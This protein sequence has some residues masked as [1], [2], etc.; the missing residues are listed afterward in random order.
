MD[1]KES[2]IKSIVEESN[3]TIKSTVFRGRSSSILKQPNVQNE[4]KNN[5]STRRVSFSSNYIKTFTTDTEKNTIWDTTVEE[6]LSAAESSNSREGH[7]LNTTLFNGK[8]NESE[9]GESESSEDDF[10]RDRASTKNSADISLMEFT[11]VNS[12][13][14]SNV[15]KPDDPTNTSGSSPD[16][17]VTMD[18]TCV[19]P[20][21]HSKSGNQSTCSQSTNTEDSSVS[22]E[23]TCV[24][25]TFPLKSGNQSTTTEDSSISMEFTCVNPTFH[26]KPGNQSTY[27]QSTITKDSSVSMELTCV[28][29]IFHSNTKQKPADTSESVNTSHTAKIQD[30]GNT[31]VSM[32]FTCVNPIFHLNNEKKQADTSESFNAPHT[33]KIHNPENTSVP[34]EL[35]CVNPTFHS[36]TKKDQV[37]TF[38]ASRTAEIQNPGDTSLSMEFT[39]VNPTLPLNTKQATGLFNTPHTDKIQNPENTSVSMEFTCVNP[40]LHLNTKKTAESFNA[41]HTAKIQNPGNTSVSMEFTCVNPTLHSNTKKTSES[42]NASHTAKIPNPGN[43]TVPMELTCV[44]PAFNLSTKKQQADISES[45]NALHTA[46][47]QNPRNTSVSMEFTCVNPTLHSNTKKT[48]ESFNASQTAKIPNPGNTTVPMELTCVNPTLHLNPK[49][50]QADTSESFNAS[51]KAKIQNPVNTSVSM[52]FTCVNPTLHSNPKKTQ[53][54]TSESFNASHTAKIPNPGNTTVPMEFTCVNPTL[55]SNPKKT[56]ADT[57]E[58]FNA[59]HTAKIQNPGNTSVP[60]EFTC[61]NPTLHSNCNDGKGANIPLKKSPN[62]FESYALADKSNTAEFLLRNYQDKTNLSNFSML[63]CSKGISLM[64]SVAQTSTQASFNVSPQIDKDQTVDMPSMSLPDITLSS[65]QPAP[66]LPV[67]IGN[68]QIENGTTKLNQAVDLASSD[69]E[70]DKSI[71]QMNDFSKEESSDLESILQTQS[72]K[73]STLDLLC[74][75]NID[76]SAMSTVDDTLQLLRDASQLNRTKTALNNTSG[77]QLNKTYLVEDSRLEDTK[78][79]TFQDNNSDMHETHPEDHIDLFSKCAEISGNN[80]ILDRNTIEL[81]E[82]STDGSLLSASDNSKEQEDK[83]DDFK[84][85]TTPKSVSDNNAV[86]SAISGSEPKTTEEILR[87][88]FSAADFLIV[89]QRDML[90]LKEKLQSIVIDSSLPV[91]DWKKHIPTLEKLKE[92]SLR[93]RKIIA[94]KY[95]KFK[96]QLKDAIETCEKNKFV[97][98]KLPE[99]DDVIESD[100][101]ENI[102]PAKRGIVEK[103]E[104]KSKICDNSWKMIK[105]ED[106]IAVFTSFFDQMKITVE[107]CQSDYRVSGIETKSLLTDKAKPAGILIQ[108]EFLRL[109]SP[110]L[111]NNSIGRQYNILS[112]LDYIQMTMDKIRKCYKTFKDLVATHDM[113]ISKDFKV[114]FFLLDEYSIIKWDFCID[115]SD[116][117]KITKES[118]SVSASIGKVNAKH[119]LDLV[120]QCPKGLGFL[121]SFIMKVEE[122]LETLRKRKRMLKLRK[123]QRVCEE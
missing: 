73:S 123:I 20:S 113:Q 42:F 61:V 100:E 62:K 24:N 107:Y 115:L 76:F 105:M 119:V 50:T 70:I 77:T 3:N 117:D 106:G 58:S 103:I 28:N 68:L 22:M 21:F 75:S 97:P 54:D 82:N 16:N 111:I 36:S 19:D 15:A 90:I 114:K 116:L 66:T 32:E 64:A 102:L 34:M 91:D 92:Q 112:L 10:S 83:I 89:R 69:S 44:N 109:L 95:D 120:S 27:S 63:D 12:T 49:K 108:R 40:T 51:H 79:S 37:D 86:H 65:I 81:I 45:F 74:K 53:A 110:T 80:Y 18:F 41:P 57:S 60:M 11:C 25:P 99:D 56:Q 9:Q 14:H 122:Y 52:E 85:V 94:E 104:E 48:S 4:A 87:G 71:A 35:T 78:D 30:L 1:N 101:L 6:L 47:I 8:G 72:S 118:I 23:F 59:S 38:N 43:N 29:P 93:N 7:D 67:S 88:D 31:S 26:S 33:A 98:E 2:V 5:P 55:H 121:E 17:S 46:K 13:L 96:K 39:C 84:E